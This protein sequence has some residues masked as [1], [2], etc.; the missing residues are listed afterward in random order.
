LSQAAQAFLKHLTL[1]LA[2]S[3]PPELA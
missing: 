3:L 1:A 2:G